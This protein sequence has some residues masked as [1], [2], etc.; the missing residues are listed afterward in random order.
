MTIRVHTKSW[1]NLPHFLMLRPP[2]TA[3]DNNNTT[4]V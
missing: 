2:V 3:N 4:F 1:L